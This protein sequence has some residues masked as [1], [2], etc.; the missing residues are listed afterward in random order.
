[1]LRQFSFFLV[2]DCENKWEKIR[3][4]IKK[5][6]NDFTLD[7]FNYI[8][9]DITTLQDAGIRKEIVQHINNPSLLPGETIAIR[10]N[11]E[12]IALTKMGKSQYLSN[13]GIGYTFPTNTCF[14]INNEIVTSEGKSL[15]IV[16]SINLL[17]PS[18]LQIAVSS[19]FLP[20]YYKHG[21]ETSLWKLY[22]SASIIRKNNGDCNSLLNVAKELG[23]GVHSLLRIINSNEQ[24]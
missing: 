14:S 12:Q 22:E 8:L 20:A 2:N 4:Q 10:L 6:K 17:E 23:I 3:P 7:D 13:R 21:I 19:V 5:V 16:K 1:M 24:Q 18:A 11:T 9:N 15:G